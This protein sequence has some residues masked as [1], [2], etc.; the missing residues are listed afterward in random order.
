MR[1]ILKKHSTFSFNQP[2]LSISFI[3]SV[4]SG[5]IIQLIIRY[6]EEFILPCFVTG[7]LIILRIRL[8][9]I[10]TMLFCDEISIQ[11][12]EAIPQRRKSK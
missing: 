1:F 2:N 10:Y 4:Q 7:I 12:F 11:C 5:N 9:I 6:R 8:S 3:L